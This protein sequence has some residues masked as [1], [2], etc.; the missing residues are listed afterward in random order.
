MKRRPEGGRLA[1]TGTGK[2]PKKSD[3]VV[4]LSWEMS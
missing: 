1:P 3:T 2:E 4:G